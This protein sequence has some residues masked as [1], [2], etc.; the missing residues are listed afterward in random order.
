MKLTSRERLMRTLR[1]E[2]VDRPA[3]SFYEIDGY[4][5]NPNDPSPL[6]IYSDPSWKPVIDLAKDRS[7]SMFMARVS[8]IDVPESPL[9]ELTTTERWNDENGSLFVRTTI[10]A[11]ERTLTQLSRRDVDVDTVWVLEHFLKDIDDLKA[12]LSLPEVPI[13]G[14]PNIKAIQA[15]EEN[16]G[17]G[18]VVMLGNSDPLC[19]AAKLFDMAD[20]TIIAMTEQD[21]FRKLLDRFAK[22]I[23]ARVELTADALPGYLWRIVG[24]E[25]AAPPYLPPYLFK[26]YVL[27]YDKQ[28]VD[29]IHKHD[30]YARLHSHGRLKDVLDFIAETGCMGL[31]P[32]E[33]PGQGDVELKYVREKYGKQ[34]VLFGNLEATDLENLSTEKFAEKIKIALEEGVSSDGRG[35]VLMPSACPFGRKLNDNILPN[36]EKMIELAEELATH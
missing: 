6:N 28:I 19:C 17:D 11:G 27:G 1:G 32:I 12:Y 35:F 31:D 5:Q 20:Y 23:Y 16:I 36:Y 29:I 3:V 25:Y 33:P 8:F 4:S 15:I 24:P 13:G 26:E 14:V 21:L 9:D 7:D 10:K 34:M 18:G 22:E 30:G 2:S